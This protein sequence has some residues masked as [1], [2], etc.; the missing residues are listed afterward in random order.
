MSKV[1]KDERFEVKDKQQYRITNW[2]E[3]NRALEN[4][5]NVTFIID[6]EVI[7]NWYSDAPAQ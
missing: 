7:K 1:K 5:G 6:D 3:Y 4:R 2:P